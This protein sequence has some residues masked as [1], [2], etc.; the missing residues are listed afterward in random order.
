MHNAIK[1][2]EN[3]R[4]TIDAQSATNGSRS[5]EVTVADTGCGM[6]PEGAGM[7]FNRLYQAGDQRPESRQGL[8]LGLYICQE[9]VARQGGTI[10]VESELGKGSRFHCTFPEFDQQIAAAASEA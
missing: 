5:I 9:L 2:T 8:G 1:F 7:V 3:G 10:W 4:I 6:S